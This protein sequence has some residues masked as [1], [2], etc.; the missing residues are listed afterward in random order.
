MRE[1]I[2]NSKIGSILTLGIAMVMVFTAVS[3]RGPLNCGG[4][5]RLVKYAASA[6]VAMFFGFG[7]DKTLGST[8]WLCK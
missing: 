7:S 5:P 4:T 3:A 8:P 2:I 1:R 6:V